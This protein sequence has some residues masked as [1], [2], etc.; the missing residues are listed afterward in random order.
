MKLSPSYTY[1]EPIDVTLFKFGIVTASWNS[2]ITE[3]LQKGAYEKFIAQGIRKENIFL[4]KVPGSFE[5]IYAADKICRTQSIDALIVIGTIIKGETRH[6]EYV[7]EA[8]SQGIKDINL[9]YDVPVIF[10]V[11]TDENKRQSLDRSGG[12]GGN[13]GVE[14]ADTAIEMALFRKSLFL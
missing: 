11:L 10:C 14:C 5:L 13:K 6:F 7:C 9:R 4:W 8:V 12:K 1:I 2:D 3:N